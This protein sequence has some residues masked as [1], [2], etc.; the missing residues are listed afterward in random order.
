MEMSF[1]NRLKEG[2]CL[3]WLLFPFVPPGFH[4]K[5][6]VRGGREAA[7]GFGKRERPSHPRLMN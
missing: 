1:W 2:Q 6:A 7:V 4:V 3:V 5:A